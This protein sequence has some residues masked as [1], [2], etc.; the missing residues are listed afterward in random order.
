MQEII[1]AIE[2]HAD[3]AVFEALEIPATYRAAIIRKEDAE[4]F[5]GVESKDKDPRRSIKIDQVPVPELAHGEALIA[6]MASSINYTTVWTSIFEPVSTF[7]FLQ[8]YA[9]SHPDGA[10]H[11]LGPRF[12]NPFPHLV[13]CSVTP[14]HILMGLGMIFPITLL[15][16][17]PPVSCCGL[18]RGSTHSHRVIG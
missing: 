16:Q 17:M 9:K 18:V 4:M 11:D 10:R 1:L 8:R 5:A 3:R 7:G 6:V 12:L 14:S 13:F 2:S 15:A